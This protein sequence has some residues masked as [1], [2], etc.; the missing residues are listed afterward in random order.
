MATVAVC[1]RMVPGTVRPAQVVSGR[2]DAVMRER[3]RLARRQYV[4]GMAGDF[5]RQAEG[6]R[7][8]LLPLV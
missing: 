4:R 8:T 3:M 1:T 6:G 2:G 7:R 5:R